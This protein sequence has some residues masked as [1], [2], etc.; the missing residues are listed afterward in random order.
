MQG[1]P[2]QTG[3]SREFWQNV[4]HWRREWQTTPVY[5]AWEPHE[6]HKR[7]KRYDTKRWVLQV[8]R[9][10]YVSWE[11]QR[12]ITNRPRMNEAAR[13]KQIQ[14]SV[15]DVSGDESKIRCCKEQYCIRTWNVRSM[16]QRKLDVFKQE[17]VRINTDILG[18]NELKW[19]GT[20]KFNSDNHYIYYCGQ[21]SHRG[22]GVG[23]KIKRVQN[24]VLGY[25]L[26]NDRMI[27]VSLQGRTF[28]TTES[29]CMP[30]PPMLK[31]VKLIS[32]RKT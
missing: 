32:S 6:L 5:L 7:P 17:M 16:N 13:P 2:R 3:H 11:E 29:K 30:L 1:Y 22:N 25:N 26:K 27:S 24:T 4:I 18:I 15:M 20:S 28:K 31:K 23:L 10:Q 8:W 9:V 21:E 19:L 12:R 14:R